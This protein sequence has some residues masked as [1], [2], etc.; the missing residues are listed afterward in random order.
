[1]HN[2]LA[3]ALLLAT[4][5]TLAGHAWSATSQDEVDEAKRVQQLEEARKAAAEARKAVAEAEAGEAK[6]KLGTLDTSELTKP[7]GEA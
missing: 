5:L 1:M 3:T 7:T 6:A 4:G 2:H